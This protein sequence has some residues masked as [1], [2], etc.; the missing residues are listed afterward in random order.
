MI[1]PK[2]LRERRASLEMLRAWWDCNEVIYYELLS[3]N[4]AK[5]SARNSSQIVAFN[6]S[7]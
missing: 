1:F 2:L 4:Q 3:Q 5:N 7:L 6:E